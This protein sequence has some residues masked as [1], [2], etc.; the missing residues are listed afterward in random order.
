VK[1]QHIFYWGDIDAYGLEILN[2]YRE[3]GVPAA[4]LLM[5]SHTYETYERFG[6][7]TGANGEP[8]KP[9]PVRSL[10]ALTEPEHALYTRLRDPDHLQHRRIEQERIPL[11]TALSVVRSQLE[12]SES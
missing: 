1:A 9:G 3:D 10:P 12:T 11:T 4:S 7:N 2:G 5:D 8:I 6:T